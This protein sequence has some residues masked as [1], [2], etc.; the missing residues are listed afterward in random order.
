[1]STKED[2]NMT[3]KPPVIGGKHP[4]LVNSFLIVAIA[5]LGILIV[6]FSLAL[7]TKHGQK[8]TVPSVENLSYSAAVE[9]LHGA[10]FRVE[11]RDSL[12][13]DNIKPGLVIEQFPKSGE[14]A[15]PGRKVFLYINALHPKQVMIDEE[16]RPGLNALRGMP[17]R[18][19]LSRL[20]ELGFKKIK[21]VKVLGTSKDLVVRILA[22]GRPVRKRQ[23]IPVSAYIVVEVYDGRL[24]ALYDSLYNLEMARDPA[25][26]PEYPEE[27]SY[28]A[29]SGGYAPAEEGEESQGTYQYIP[30]ENT[31]GGNENTNSEPEPETIGL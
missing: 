17:E 19:A 3:T 9:K 22:D 30:E 12:Y 10:G 8:A 25:F 27:S 13:L 6:Y 28:S 15:K 31:G 7:F 23:L 29:G 1:M 16:N 24:D 2:P 11:I 4:I 14:I 5:A 21:V 18:T 20:Q 26:A